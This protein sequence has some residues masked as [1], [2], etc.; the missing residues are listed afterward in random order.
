M[1]AKNR[2]SPDDRL[3]S[4]KEIASYLD[5]TPRTVMRWEA[6]GLP[7]HR[8]QTGKRASVYAFKSE[9]DAWVAERSQSP[10]ADEEEAPAPS[11]RGLWVGIA[12]AAALAVLAF[13]L[14]PG[15][16]GPP[17]G[18]EP[19]ELT[20]DP[21]LERSPAF[22]PDGSQVAYAR[23]RPGAADFDIFV[24]DRAS[25]R[26]RPLAVGPTNELAPVWSP[27][28]E[29]IVYVREKPGGVRML[30][31]EIVQLEAG[32][33]PDELGSA[34][35]VLGELSRPVLYYREPMLLGPYFAWS[36]DG[37]TLI[38]PDGTPSERSVSGRAPPVPRGLFSHDL[39][40]GKRKRLTSVEDVV[41]GD[42]EPA[43]SPDGRRLAFVRRFR[44]YYSELFVLDLDAP[45]E[46]PRQ[47]THFGELVMTPRFT[48][49]GK[50]I[51]VSAGQFGAGRAL[52]R[53]DVGA[54]REPE[55]I[56]TPPRNLYGF[57]LAPDGRTVV[58]TRG[59]P[60]MD[61]WGVRVDALPHVSAPVLTSGG[62]DK[63]PTLSP[64]GSRMAF[65][66]D[67][68]ETTEIWLASAEGSAPRQ[69][70]HGAGD[71]DD[72]L[73]W[74]PDGALLATTLR[75]P[76]GRDVTT[77][78]VTTGEIT[79]LTHGLEA[80]SVRWSPDGKWIHFR[81]KQG[82]A[83]GGIHRIARTG[84]AI[85]R[86]ASGLCLD[87]ASDAYSALHVHEN[88]KLIARRGD[89]RVILAG[90]STPQAYAPARDRVFFLEPNGPNRA[91]LEYANLDGTERATFLNVPDVG[92]DL[93]TD[94][95]ATLLRWSQTEQPES[96]LMLVGLD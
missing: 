72:S 14:R 30:D 9:L 94:A 79:R 24:L 19:V 17:V 12:A 60:R 13:A 26:T 67:R 76:E 82:D 83:A 71:G 77:V 39:A 88:R 91:T 11:R 68:G 49:D 95:D 15:S 23:R 85:E 31:L 90:L 28:G 70:T 51:L 48:P 52:W 43:L 89:K 16:I 55:R 40:S 44:P 4:W 6:V 42:T 27:D 46:P 7:V 45:H 75:G 34:G 63:L 3:S 53:V 96:D 66:S 38:V 35:R 50:S 92:R 54:S 8:L 36:A 69:L 47:L 74:S 87:F 56:L 73:D 25:A 65:F 33:A 64:D 32:A 58:F 1:G 81:A 10:Q 80:Q 84:G 2:M 61:I 29:S 86:V 37:R 93:T 59:R 18:G 57:D 21:G 5:T 62:V 78:D 22:S 20:R 41:G